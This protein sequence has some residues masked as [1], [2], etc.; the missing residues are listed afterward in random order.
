MKQ[1]AFIIVLIWGLGA[2]ATTG[3]VLGSALNPATG[4][5]LYAC[6][7]RIRSQSATTEQI[8]VDLRTG[9]TCDPARV[10]PTDG[11]CQCY[12]KEMIGNQIVA[13]GGDGK[14]RAIHST[15]QWQ[16]FTASDSL[17][18][19][20]LNSLE[21]ELG[22]EILGAEYG[23]TYCYKGPFATEGIDRSLGQYLVDFTLQGSAY[24]V[25]LDS[26]NIKYACDLRNR[27]QSAAA[28][29][30]TSNPNYDD[31]YADFQREENIYRRVD[32]KSPRE[33]GY[34][35]VRLSLNQVAHEV[36][37]FCVIE[38]RFKE[39]SGKDLKRDKSGAT[40]FQGSLAVYQGSL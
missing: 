15:S 27:G 20:R 38:V 37:R 32:D 19:G 4:E 35:Q 11:P 1:V 10:S 40:S 28:R 3:S 9:G 30:P 21:A 26:V 13:T 24:A 17:F 39:R 6:N 25:A 29:K 22:S 12:A 31:L 36:P 14:I 23:L 5:E 34:Q 2:T 8:C 33:I 7:A 16:Q 18:S